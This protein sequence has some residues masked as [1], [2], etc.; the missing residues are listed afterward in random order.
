MSISAIACLALL[1]ISVHHVEVSIVGVNVFQNLS[2][3]TTCDSNSKQLIKHLD[4]LCIAEMHNNHIYKVAIYIKQ[5]FLCKLSSRVC[6]EIRHTP[7]YNLLL[8]RAL[9]HSSY[10]LMSIKSH[11]GVKAYDTYMST[12]STTQ[13]MSIMTQST[14]D[15][16]YFSQSVKNIMMGLK[17]INKTLRVSLVKAG[18]EVSHIMF[19]LSKDYNYTNWF[20]KENVIDSYPWN[21]STYVTCTV[22]R[23]MYRYCVYITCHN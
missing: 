10:L 3:D 8:R 15:N 13:N 4:M 17:H 23:Y 11:S 18:D 6:S 7:G 5:T 2:F 20:T 19:K 16:V 22:H 9:T 1:L 14:T 12:T 21:T